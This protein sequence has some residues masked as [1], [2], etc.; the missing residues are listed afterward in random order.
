[1]SRPQ[2]HC[3]RLAPLPRLSRRATRRGGAFRACPNSGST[4]SGKGAIQ[5]I[6]DPLSAT[7]LG[8]ILW[9][10]LPAIIFPLKVSVDYLWPKTSARHTNLE[11]G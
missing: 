8:Y 10:P 7:K 9:I 6:V 4:G 11:I 3:P 5:N 2:L 1:M